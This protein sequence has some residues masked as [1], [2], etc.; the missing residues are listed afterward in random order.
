MA[1]T[2]YISSAAT[3]GYV[4]GDNGN[5]GT[6]PS[7]PWRD[8][9]SIASAVA[10]SDGDIVHI[11]G[12]MNCTALWV[13]NDSITVIGE[14]GT[15]PILTLR[16]STSGAFGLSANGAGK[17]IVLRHLHLKAGSIT[18]SLIDVGGS[19]TTTIT[20]DDCRTESNVIHLRLSTASKVSVVTITNCEA[21]SAA[22]A[23]GIIDMDAG[24]TGTSIT[25]SGLA[26][27]ITTS[28]TGGRTLFA[29][30]AP[31]GETAEATVSG[32]T[33]RINGGSLT[34][35]NQLIG[36]LLSRIDGAVIE[37]CNIT[38]HSMGADTSCKVYGIGSVAATHVLTS[39]F[40]RNNIARID[41][42]GGI[43]IT[44]GADGGA[45]NGA[46]S[47]Q[48]YGNDVSGPPNVTTLHGIM[49]GGNKTCHVYNNRVRY[50]QIAM[51]AKD[52][53]DA[54]FSH[55]VVDKCITGG[56]AMRCKG[57][58]RAIFTGNLHMIDG[59]FSAYPCYLDDS[60]V[61]TNSTLCLYYG[62]A[63]FIYP[64]ATAPAYVVYLKDGDQTA[65]FI[66]NNWYDASAIEFLAQGV[67]KT[68][69]E[70]NGLAYV[71]GDT[72]FQ[73]RPRYRTKLNHRLLTNSMMV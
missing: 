47:I 54:V 43:L 10:L 72:S 52:T 11:N 22:Q 66:G 51:I 50:T 4:V 3:N 35:T 42:R 24:A 26:L 25:I 33:G 55:N 27:D 62:N 68:L 39:G 61:P 29:L 60:D 46:D 17:T 69:A 16:S 7:T 32:V 36:I 5:N 67:A 65:T 58:T 41:S 15:R 38:M 63:L 18:N 56:Q 8:L 31:T 6:D 13:I 73:F 71:A 28:G 70:W 23:G 64:G 2:Y 12:D 9:D 19:G 37:N 59:A 14:P 57:A 34:T 30:N 49:V 20:L 21:Y 53:E 44:A 48:I 45:Y 40:I 1:N